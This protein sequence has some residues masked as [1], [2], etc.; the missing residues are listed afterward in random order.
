MRFSAEQAHELATFLSGLAHPV[1]LHLVGLLLEE[2]RNVSE[3]MRA[4][5]LPQA[6][7]SRH[8]QTLR[9][10]GCCTARQ[11]DSWVYYQVRDPLAVQ[12][13]LRLADGSVQGGADPRGN[14]E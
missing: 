13:L 8:L 4:L 7:V 1:R 2:E 10:C 12:A 14:G 9:H 6:R 3:L 5:D 11:E